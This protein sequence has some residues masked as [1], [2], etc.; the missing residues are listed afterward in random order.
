VVRELSLSLSLSL[1]MVCFVP[2]LS[3]ARFGDFACLIPGKLLL[4]SDLLLLGFISYNLLVY[5][6]DLFIFAHRH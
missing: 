4:S 3:Q 1:S 2:M 6:P 5:K